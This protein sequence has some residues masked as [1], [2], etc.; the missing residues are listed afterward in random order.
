MRALKEITKIVSINRIKEIKLLDNVILTDRNNK[1]GELYRGI[2]QERFKTDQDA[3]KEIYGTNNDKRYGWLK[4]NYKNRILNNLFFLDINSSSFSDYHQAKLSCAKNLALC[5]IL[6]V[7]G[8]RYSSIR[9]A[10]Q[11]LKH[12][13]K[14]SLNDI[15][16]GCARL[17]KDY[18][19]MMGDFKRHNLFQSEITYHEK[20]LQA[21]LLAEQY[22]QNVII[23]YV[24]SVSTKLEV[25]NIAGDYVKE[26][27]GLSKK[28]HS[29]QLHYYTY[30]I[31]ALKYQL[32]G[33]YRKAIEVYNELEAFLSE[34]KDYYQKMVIANI[35]RSKLACCLHL[36][37]FKLGED[38]AQ[39]CLALYK[40]GSNN[41]FVFNE[42]YFLYAV[43][44]KEYIVAKKI[45][46]EVIFHSRFSNVPANQAEK[47]KIYEVYTFFIQEQFPNELKKIRTRRF[48]YNAFLVEVPIF[49]KDKRGYNIA[50]LIIHILLM[51]TM[52]NFNL[53]ID[54]MDALRLYHNRHLKKEED[55]RSKLFI[56][57]LMVME[58]Q[59][60]DYQKTKGKA[61]K[62]LDEMH[63]H[64]FQ[65]EGTPI[66][67][68]IIPYETLWEM[69]L[70]ILK[71]QQSH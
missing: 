46:N 39:I 31:K 57:M 40:R 2:A 24:N 53:I 67:A 4:T 52:G 42:L 49:S 11:T 45:L 55:L 22:Y 18:Y 64:K 37:D 8:A 25:S 41:W 66:D 16:I 54:R 36:E 68:E 47:W 19:A 32:K 71:K 30:R 50:I 6:S 12:A 15:V 38:I 63:S 26:L 56:K 9:L 60:F 14:Y 27:E 33:G 59:S 69:V 21:D 58:K 28:Y 3:C 65:Y 10:T 70:N 43:R 35:N 17:L 29:F 51:L 7:Y 20:L 23:N 62:Y 34:N 61:Q 48:D 44:L 5:T 1:L 13:K